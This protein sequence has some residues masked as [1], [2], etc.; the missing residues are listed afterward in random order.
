MNCVILAKG[1]N[2]RRLGEEK[3]FF[4][5]NGKPLIEIVFE[6]VKNLFEKIYIVTTTPEKFNKFEKE[7]VELLRD[8]IKCG[9][10][11]GIYTG[12]L[13]SETYFNFVLG[14]DLIFISKEF[15]NYIEKIKDNYD[16]IVPR[17]EK[18]IQPLCGIYS[19]KVIQVVKRKIDEGKF[20]VLDIL[21]ELNVRFIDEEELSCFGN[22]DFLLFNL[23]TKEDKRKAEY[24]WEKFF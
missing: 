12:L 8:D 20:R 23:N 9:P 6:R 14:V 24:I 18:F 17:T 22:P 16:I 5:I 11:G 7:N 21:K 1:E 13:K 19:K 3:P 10:L 15:I 2:S 4:L